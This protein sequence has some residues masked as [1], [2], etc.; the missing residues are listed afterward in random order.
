M[1]ATQRDLK[2]AI[3]YA[4]EN[5][6]TIR[7]ATLQC[8]LDALQHPRQCAGTRQYREMADIGSNLRCTKNAIAGSEFCRYHQSQDR[9]VSLMAF[10]DAQT[11]E[12][13]PAYMRGTEEI[14]DNPNICALVSWEC[15]HHVEDVG[16]VAELHTEIVCFDCVDDAKAEHA[17]RCEVERVTRGELLSYADTIPGAL[18]CAY[19]GKRIEGV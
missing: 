17:N 11:P 5:G 6:D 8:E 12:D 14:E 13:V 19:C 2:Q 16:M 1:A 3:A 18:E 4:I 7:A 15:D 9:R 10:H